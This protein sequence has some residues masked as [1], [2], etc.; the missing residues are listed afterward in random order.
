M[1]QR[2]KFRLETVLRVRELRER[3]ARRKVGA[4]MGEIA[5]IDRQ[6]EMS[7]QDIQQ[8]QFGLVERQND[9]LIDPRELIRERAWITHLRRGIAE[10]RGV[11]AERQRELDT[12]REE[13]R[14]ARV[15]TRMLENLR[16]RQ[17]TEH[18]R[19]AARREQDAMDEVAQRLHGVDAGGLTYS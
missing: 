5:E 17:L 15:Q 7:F 6:I 1:A 8:R 14:Q 16:E 9:A 2:F 3:E 11:K 10:R 4:K 18:R 12:L 19:A 13:L